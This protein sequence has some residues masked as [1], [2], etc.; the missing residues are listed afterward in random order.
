M[1]TILTWYGQASYML[2]SET[3]SVLID[4]FFSNSLTGQ[5]FFRLYD[6]PVQKGSLKADYVITSHDHGDHLDIETL[7]DYITFNKVYG[8]KSS[9]DLLKAEGFSD[10]KI[11]AFNR[12]DT[13]ILGDMKFTAVYAEHTPDSIGIVVECEGVKLYFTGDSLMSPNIFGVKDFNPDILLTCINGK[14]GNMTWQEAVMLAHMLNVKTAIP[15]HYDLFA[16]NQEDPA[17]FAGAFEKSKIR[18]IIMTRGKPY[19]IQ[20]LL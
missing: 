15:A 10:D 6:S 4:P 16:I 1:S 17:L 13:I 11:S 2:S 14:F 18:C 8:P 7:R 3:C 9:V 5:G 12:G 20:S 19:D